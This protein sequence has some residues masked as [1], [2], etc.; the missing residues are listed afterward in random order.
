MGSAVGATERDAYSREAS[1]R[2]KRARGDLKDA[3]ETFRQSRVV[4]ERLL[5]E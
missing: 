3:Q 2:W 1:R 4:E 5:R